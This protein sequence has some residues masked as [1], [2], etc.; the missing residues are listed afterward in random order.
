MRS[1]HQEQ[2]DWLAKELSI[3]TLTKFKDWPNF[4]EITQRRNLFVHTNGIVSNQYLTTCNKY[5]VDNIE[6]IN[7]GDKLNVDRAYF[8]RTYEIF[9]EIGIKL[10][11]MVLRCLLLKKE[12]NLLG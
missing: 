9:Y 10:S 1:S 11:Q 6:N 7:K 8:E 4:I 2:F 5:K 12:P 3:S